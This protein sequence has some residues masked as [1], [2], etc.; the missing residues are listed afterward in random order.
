MKNY[1]FVLGNAPE[2]A[3]E[4]LAAIW[5]NYQISGGLVKVAEIFDSSIVD[6]LS[7]NKKP[8]E[9]IIF[10]ISGEGP[11]PREIK[12][13]L[14]SRGYKARF[15]LPKDGVE[16]SSVVVAKQQVEEI[17]LIG[18]L[19]AKTIWVQDFEEWSRRDYGRPEVEAHIG[20]LP[21]KVA[22]MMVN[23]A[24]GGTI[25]DPFCGV[26]TILAE[27]YSTNHQIFGSDI[28][29]DQL[30]KTKKNL[31]WLGAKYQLFR[32]D[33]RKISQKL[34]PNCVSSVVTEPYLGPDD[35]KKLAEL[36]SSCLADWQKVLKPGGKV[37][38]AM[39]FLVD[40]DHIGIDKVKIMGYS[41]SSGPLPYFRP[42]AVVKRYIYVLT[43]TNGP[44]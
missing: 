43:L 3:N 39:P 27:A 9:R 2:L 31:D 11:D 13:E 29:S 21:P 4:E 44:Y 1:L 5:P 33:A 10:G 26:G 40:P 30:A 19:K 6:E 16:L 28:S 32:E 41:V 36:Y 22:R 8:G 24:G 17:Y 7:E 20:M 18:D 12:E 38:M 35:P 37:V 42:R 25:L 23:I 15:I 34:A 14:E